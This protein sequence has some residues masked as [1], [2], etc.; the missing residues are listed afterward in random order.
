MKPDVF[1]RFKASVQNPILTLEYYISGVDDLQKIIAERKPNDVQYRVIVRRE[2]CVVDMDKTSR[3]IPFYDKYQYIDGH[4]II[5]TETDETFEFI[6]PKILYPN[7]IKTYLLEHYG[8]TL[9]F[10]PDESMNNTPMTF[11]VHNQ[12]AVGLRSFATGAPSIIKW[13]TVSY[14]PLS[15][16]DTVTDEHLNQIWPEKTGSLPVGLVEL[17]NRGTEKVH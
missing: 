14:R 2:N 7:D 9:N 4:P 1:A 8:S 3:K 5:A 6:M 10:K 15:D 17:F 16:K 13:E 11:S 12:S